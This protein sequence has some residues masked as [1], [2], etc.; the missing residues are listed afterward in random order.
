ML[1]FSFPPQRWTTGIPEPYTGPRAL[2]SSPCAF[3]RVLLPTES[4]PWSQTLNFKHQHTQVKGT[5]ASDTDRPILRSSSAS[6]KRAPANT[7]T[8][9]VPSPT[10]CSCIWEAIT[11]I[12]AAGCWTWYAVIN[13]RKHSPLEQHSH[14]HFL[15]D[16]Q[17]P[18]GQ[19]ASCLSAQIK[20][21]KHTYLTG[22][23]Y[24]QP[25]KPSAFTPNLENN[26]FP[27]IRVSNFQVFRREAGVMAHTFNCSLLIHLA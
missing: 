9:F 8:K 2:N 17:M 10:S 5:L 21:S 12:F 27:T 13:K 23:R 7:R 25:H 22:I 15:I 20:M 3:P 14:V 19:L 1:P 18:P 26:A 24:T 16:R 6:S 11:I 4:W